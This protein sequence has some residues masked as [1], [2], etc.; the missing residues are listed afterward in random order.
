MKTS[1]AEI[2]DF[3]EFK[4]IVD[5]IEEA[6]LEPG[7]QLVWLNVSVPVKSKISLQKLTSIFKKDLQINKVVHPSVGMMFHIRGTVSCPNLS[8]FIITELKKR[9][10]PQSF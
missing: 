8:N 7:A 1:D 9:K 3:S 2:T 4:P 6:I 10:H 5:L